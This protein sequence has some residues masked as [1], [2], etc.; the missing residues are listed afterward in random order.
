MADHLTLNRVVLVGHSIAG[1]ELTKSAAAYP[2]RVSALV[3]LDAAYDRT[4]VK[5]L[6]Q[7]T[8]P[9]PPADAFASAE[10][11]MAY[12]A[13]VWNWRAPDAEMYNTRSIAADGRS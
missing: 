6:P 8:Y 4:K 9:E 13:R 7:P 5:Q 1:D 2:E 3:Y 10:K 11:Y 12:L